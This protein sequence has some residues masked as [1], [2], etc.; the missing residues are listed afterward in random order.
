MQA[1]AAVRHPAILRPIDVFDD[2][3][4]C[5]AVLERFDGRRL[6][7]L[8]AASGALHPRVAA[9]CGLEVASALAALHERGIV[10]GAG[11]LEAILVA[12]DG[13]AKLRV[14]PRRAAWTTPREEAERADVRS[15]GEALH[16][17]ATGRTS[18]RPLDLDGVPAELAAVVRGALEPGWRARW[19]AAQVAAALRD[20]LRT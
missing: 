17:M 4:G 6:D 14:E 16:A 15:F 3:L 12:A 11:V 1:L 20:A 8:L 18:A 2:E 13:A 5:R 9:H 10:H 7:A 19:T